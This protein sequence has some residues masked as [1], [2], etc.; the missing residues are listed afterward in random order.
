MFSTALKTITAAA[1]LTTALA[2]SLGA[3]QAEAKVF[4]GDP[5]TT[6]HHSNNHTVGTHQ[7]GGWQPSSTHGHHQGHTNHQNAPHNTQTG[8]AK[9]LSAVY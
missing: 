9:N 8:A 7:N 5:G 6:A 2:S 4:A 3:N 1:L